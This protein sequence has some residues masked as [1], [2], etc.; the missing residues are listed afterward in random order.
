MSY[1]FE[2]Q[3]PFDSGFRRIARE[4]IDIARTLL[5]HAG[6]S[7]E[8]V[9]SIR[10][11]LK[12]LRALMRLCR[13]CLAEAD[14]KKYNT[15]FRDIARML[16]A[17]RDAHV[18][19]KTLAKLETEPS[20]SKT[21]AAALRALRK[22]MQKS[23]SEKPERMNK[24]AATKALQHLNVARKEVAKLHFVRHGFEPIGEG[25]ESSFR[26]GR[27]AFLEALEDPDD[28][29]EHEWRKDVQRHWRHMQLLRT[30]WPGMCSARIALGA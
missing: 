19:T 10:K 3:E 23:L 8:A 20:N 4:Q 22:H 29:T 2:H 28:D 24:K 26:Q 16:A 1:R 5:D 14:Y 18:M 17:S 27:K 6:N 11:S 15:R 13:P 25:L 21:E 7:P 30:L 12:R 9:H